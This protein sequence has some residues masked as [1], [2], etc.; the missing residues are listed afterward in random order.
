MTALMAAA[1]SG[2][3]QMVTLIANA[4]ADI[5]ITNNEGLTAL[6]CAAITGDPDIVGLL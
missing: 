6:M 3:L 4:K 2:N 5:N 1:M